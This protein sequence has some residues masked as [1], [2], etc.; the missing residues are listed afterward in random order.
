MPGRQGLAEGQGRSG[1]DGVHFLLDFS[2]SVQRVEKGEG[3]TVKG[4]S[5]RRD[6][7]EVRVN[8]RHLDP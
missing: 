5:K 1:G 4:F 3:A 6:R 8:Y 7:L 2:D